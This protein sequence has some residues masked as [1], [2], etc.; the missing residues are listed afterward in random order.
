MIDIFLVG[1][2][3]LIWD[4]DAVCELRLEHRIC[5]SLVGSLPRKPW[6]STTTSLPMS[7]S[8]E[9]TYLLV[10]MRFARVVRR[11]AVAMESNHVVSVDTFREDRQAF[12]N[13][14][15]RIFSAQ[16][17]TNRKRFYGMVKKS[18]KHK[19]LTDSCLA[20]NWEEED[21]V[22]SEVTENQLD[23]NDLNTIASERVPGHANVNWFDNPAVSSSAEEENTFLETD[24]GKEV[25]LIGSHS[26][27]DEDIN[28]GLQQLGTKHTSTGSDCGADV[29][30]SSNI[31]TRGSIEQTVTVV[32]GCD[33]VS[34]DQVSKHIFKDSSPDMRSDMNGH[35]AS[36]ASSKN[37]NKST[38]VFHQA[39][40][41]RDADDSPSMDVR[42]GVQMAANCEQQNTNLK[43][44]VRIH[45]PTRCL[46]DGSISL[47]DW[48]FP[49]TERQHDSAAVFQD[50]WNR[51]NYITTASKFGADF[52]VYPGDPLRYHAYFIVLVLARDDE[53]TGC[54]LLSY[55]RLGASVKKNV[56]L[57][58]VS[59]QQDVRYISLSWTPMKSGV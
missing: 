36:N 30:V 37:N 24:W 42:G 59:G 5:G 44:S 49:E 29:E 4:A 3:L 2:E 17:A 57:A 46:T 14:Q 48:K 18:R 51:G 9:E 54:D 20:R 43:N 19:K 41:A 7:L 1:S 53:L 35:E 56:V 27:H 38:D 45:I 16:Q 25:E 13:Q 55:G 32:N 15:I 28:A 11:N 52:C 31:A 50:L 21:T 33:G 47:A 26:T 34:C 8:K 23:L 12:E 58:S 39:D 6:Q 22:S 40:L 10:K